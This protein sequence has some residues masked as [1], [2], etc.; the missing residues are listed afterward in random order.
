[1]AATL[2]VYDVIEDRELYNLR[3]GSNYDFTYKHGVIQASKEL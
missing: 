2:H 3:T 1:M